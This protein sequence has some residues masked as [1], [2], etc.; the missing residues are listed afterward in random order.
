MTYIDY[1]I[2]LNRVLTEMHKAM[3]S[4]NYEIAEQLVNNASHILGSLRLTIH[5]L[6]M[7]E[8]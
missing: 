3:K 4:E 8:E 2:E 6:N 1:L 7:K 5:D